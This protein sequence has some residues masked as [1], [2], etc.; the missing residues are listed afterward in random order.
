MRKGRG[1][2]GRR[3]LSTITPIACIRNC[4]MIRITTSAAITSASRRKQNAAATS[5]SANRETCRNCST[6]VLNFVYKLTN[7]E[8]T[9]VVVSPDQHRP[10]KSIEEVSREGEG[11]GRKA[12]CLGRVEVCEPRENDPG[13]RAHH[14]NP[15]QFRQPTNRGDA[16]VKQQHR[17][18]ANQN[19]DESPASHHPTHL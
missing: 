4:N 16:P 15:E 5:P 17:N 7:V 2:S 10:A 3:I 9:P 11:P 14:P 8:V 13:N 12:E 6:S 1:M 18:N 19:G